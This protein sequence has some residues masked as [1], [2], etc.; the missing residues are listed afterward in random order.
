VLQAWREWTQ[1]ELPDE[2]ISVGRVLNVPPFPEVAE[3]LRGR[4]FAVVEAVYLGEEPQGAELLAPLRTLGPEIDSFSIVPAVAL[5]HL[6]M[7]PEQ[8]VP[9][10]GD[11]MLLRDLPAEGI[12][13]FVDAATGEA[14]SALLSAEIRQLAGAIARPAPEHGA[15]GSI[16]A[17]YITYT[18]G[19]APTP[20][21]RVAVEAQVAGVQQALSGWNASHAYMN[22]SERPIDSR[23]LYPRSYT[24][25]RLQA[26]KAK[27]DPGDMIQS[28][29]PIRPA[30]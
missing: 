17:P 18:V 28:N 19:S 2:V 30:R 27:Y 4:S 20:E 23:M 21:L 22:F 10:K 13:A 12:D 29:H 26:I 14:G 3:P 25:R 1:Q 11:G 5:S 7:D 24:Y 16:E 6:H 9:G 8:P 15:A